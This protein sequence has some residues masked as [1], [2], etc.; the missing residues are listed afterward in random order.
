MEIPLSGILSNRREVMKEKRICRRRGL[1]YIVV[2]PAYYR[3]KY[4]RWNF[5]SITRILKIHVSS[6]PE[7]AS[8]QDAGDC[9]NNFMLQL[10]RLRW[11]LQLQGQK[12]LHELP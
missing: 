1:F 8:V 12:L 11:Y 7:E 6:E 2:F 4:R 10:L 5:C 3:K 9:N